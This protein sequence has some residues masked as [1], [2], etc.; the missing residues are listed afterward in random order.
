MKTLL[1]EVKEMFEEAD[2]YRKKGLTV[3]EYEQRRKIIKAAM[4]VDE[5]E[6]GKKAVN[7]N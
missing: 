5:Q 6:N 1:E 3:F 4:A 7:E 2:K